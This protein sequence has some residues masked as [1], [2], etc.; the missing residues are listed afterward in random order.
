[1]LLSDDEKILYQ[2]ISHSTLFNVTLKMIVSKLNVSVNKPIVSWI[3]V[4]K[5]LLSKNNFPTDRPPTS[6]ILPFKN[7][8]RSPIKLVVERKVKMAHLLSFTIIHL[9]S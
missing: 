6:A 4:K 9:S 5:L 1:M 7:S 2:K 3:R 8:L